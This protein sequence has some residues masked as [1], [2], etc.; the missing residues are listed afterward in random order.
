ML[1]IYPTHF[2]EETP[3]ATIGILVREKSKFYKLK[4]VLREYGIQPEPVN[5]S[6]GNPYTPGVKLCSMHSSKGLEFDYVIVID[7]IEPK[8]DEDTDTQEFWEVERRLLY[9]SIT[10][11][12]TYLQLYYYGEGSRLLKELKES[13]YENLTV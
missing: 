4:H 7:L 8:L 6:E 13:L 9:V 5:Q 11:A 2:C 10:R 12:V 3:E 1:F